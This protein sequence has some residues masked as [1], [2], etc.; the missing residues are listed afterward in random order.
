MS[1]FVVPRVHVAALVKYARAQR[2]V[3]EVFSLTRQTD[4][5]LSQVACADILQREN[6]RSCEGRYPHDA[7]EFAAE[8]G[9][10]FTTGEISAAPE[11]THA[12]AFKAAACLRYQ[13]CECDDYEATVAAAILTA[14]SA[15]AAARDPAGAKVGSPAWE[16][17]RGWPLYDATE[18]TA[19]SPAG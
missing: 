19:A 9:P 3:G 5:Q 4:S 14:I 2:L 1:A 10:R 7:H 11:L 12:E 16:R 13:S 17:G 6:I 15:H 18:V 8:L